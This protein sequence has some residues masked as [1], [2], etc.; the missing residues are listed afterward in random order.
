MAQVN[1]L[2]KE[3]AAAEIRDIFE[4][5]E[6]KYGR[7]PNI[8]GAMGHRPSVLKTFLPFYGAVTQEGNIEPRYKELAYLKTSMLN[9]C[10]YCSRAHIAAAKK[11]GIS[12]EEIEALQFYQG[13][14][15][16]DEKDKATLLYAERITRG[17]AGIREGTLEDLKK[18]YTEDQIV[19]LTLVICVANFTNRFNDALQIVPDLG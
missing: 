4:T 10:Q 3:K 18:Y 15:L 7:V 11:A 8:F 16:F 12:E 13:S 17:A 9:G 5:M 6:A 1:P 19:E 2:P 14:D